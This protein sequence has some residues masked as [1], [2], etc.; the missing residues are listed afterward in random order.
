MNRVSRLCLK[1]LSSRAR[2]C[3]RITEHLPLCY[4]Q[5]QERGDL[6]WNTGYWTNST[7]LILP[8]QA[9][10]S[11]LLSV[12]DLWTFFYIS[13]SRD[14]LLQH[15]CIS[16]SYCLATTQ[17]QQAS[18]QVTRT[19]LISKTYF[20]FRK[21]MIHTRYRILHS[22]TPVARSLGIPFGT[23]PPPPMHPLPLRNIDSANQRVNRSKNWGGE[24]TMFTTECGMQCVLTR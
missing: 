8:R 6:Q 10:Q 11:V 18:P 9:Y 4:S 13:L 1:T 7:P 22:S 20:P 3:R 19:G 16:R 14:F 15:V 2:Q 21:T 23:S 5:G 12:G 17:K 24:S